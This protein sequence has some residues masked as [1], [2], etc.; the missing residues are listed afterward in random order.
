MN[1]SSEVHRCPRC[2]QPLTPV[3]GIEEDY[4]RCHHCRAN[5][6]DWNGRVVPYSKGS[7]P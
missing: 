4:L 6:V 3:V 1:S 5:F 7:S 2:K